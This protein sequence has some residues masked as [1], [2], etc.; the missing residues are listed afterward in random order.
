MKTLPLT[1]GAVTI[2]D[3]YDYETFKSRKWSFEPRIGYAI[4][5]ERQTDG[6]EKRLYLHRLV[7]LA[8]EGQVVHHKNGDRL[9]NRSEN[10]EVHNSHSEHFRAHAVTDGPRTGCRFRGVTYNRPF[11][12]WVARLQIDG[13]RRHIGYFHSPEEAARAWDKAAREI[14]GPGCFQN[15]PDS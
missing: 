10:L 7:A 11:G 2:L 6:S 1:H 4:R 15:F 13:E 14:L 5:S 8:R 12:R 9:D 3:D